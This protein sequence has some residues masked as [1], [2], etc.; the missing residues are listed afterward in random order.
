M[1]QSV[2]KIGFA[3]LAS[4]FLFAATA[5]ADL[6]NLKDIATGFNSPIGVDYHQPT[7]SL[8][9]SANYPS[10]N[11]HNFE[12][13]DTNGVHTQFS[14]V[15]GHTDEIY[16][17]AARTTANGWTAGDTYTGNGVEGQI[18][19][20]SADGTTVTNPWVSLPG[21]NGLLRGGLAF[22]TTGQFG[23]DLIVG[24]TAGQLWKIDSAGNA[25]KIGQAG[26]S[27]E[28]EGILVI[29]ND[30]SRYGALAGKI[31]TGSDGNHL[32]AFDGVNLTPTVYGG[33]TSTENL[34]LPTAGESFYGV[35]FA[36]GKLKGAEAS[37]WTPYVGDII[38][39]EENGALE[40]LKWDP[41]L[42]GGLGGIA[43]TLLTSVPQWEGATFAPTTLP[44]LI[45]EPSAVILLGTVACGLGVLTR[46]KKRS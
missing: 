17:A 7:N 19:K 42:N 21:A 4:M 5:S 11:P 20:I 38:L 22:D 30:P 14:N 16:M 6:I 8:I 9:L 28:L 25:T 26:T 35:D 34:N 13:V 31:L 44:G 1:S 27:E 33:F 36:E 15:S 29:P 40:D 45:P 43:K 32:N 23:F 18:L 24:T 41:T 39:G 10:G 37:Q 12:L 2:P 3:L 46:R